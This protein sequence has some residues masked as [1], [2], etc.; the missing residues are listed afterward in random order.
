MRLADKG[1]YVASESTFYRLLRKENLLTHRLRSKAPERVER[2]ETVAHA[3][4]KVWCW[5]ITNLRSSE[6]GY[7]YKLYM[8]EDIYSRKIV[9]WDVLEA[10]HENCSIKVFE[11]VLLA[12]KITGENLRLHADNGQPMRGAGMLTKVLSLGVRPSFSRPSVSNDNAFIESLFKTMKFTPQYPNKPFKSL[13]SAKIWVREFVTWYND[14][15]HSSLNYITPNQRHNLKD[16]EILQS[17]KLLYLDA[18]KRNPWRWSG[19]I[20]SWEQPTLAKLN[21]RGTRMVC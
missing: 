8:F 6:K 20:R 14:R 7:F 13:E 18:R 21:S 16:D 19:K 10:E 1:V 11:S 9:G 3:P 4:N 12:E 5:D 17:R 15:L 2:V